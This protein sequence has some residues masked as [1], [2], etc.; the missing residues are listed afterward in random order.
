MGKSL[1]ARQVT[2]L[3]VLVYLL[4]GAALLPFYRY[5][6]A[7]DAI[8]YY[9]IARH[10]L[11]GNWSCAVNGYWG[12]MLSWLM[13]PFL[14]VGLSP[15]LA[16]KLL[17]L[18]AGAVMLLAVSR[19]VTLYA[20]PMLIRAFVLFSCIPFVLYF[21]WYSLSP[22]LLLGVMVALYCVMIFSE[23]YARKTWPGFLCGA[24]G[25]MAYFCKQYGFM[26]F[27][28]HFTLFSLWLFIS[29]EE[30]SRRRQVAV[31]YAL[32]MCV[33]MVL[34]ACWVAALNAKYGHPTLGTAG[35]YNQSILGPDSVG[36]THH[37]YGFLPLP[38]EDAVSA[39]EDPSF[40]PYEPWRP[41][42]SARAMVY[43][44]KR[45]LYNIGALAE[46]YLILSVFSI[47][48]MLG[49]A[50]L[51]MGPWR[52]FRTRREWYPLGVLA[53]FSGG[54]T[55]VLIDL[56]FFAIAAVLT[57]LVTGLVLHALLRN[58]FFRGPLRRATLCVILLLS[59]VVYPGIKL[60]GHLHTGKIYHQ[61]ARPLAALLGH[62][63][64]LASNEDWF[65]SLYYAALTGNKYLGKAHADWTP[66]A[67]R[68][69]LAAH[70]ID[71]YFV[72]GVDDPNLPF[73]AATHRELRQDAVPGL[74]VFDISGVK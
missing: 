25:A 65:T 8:S 59:F 53:V 49:L 70:A 28:A 18:L 72:W 32:G 55:L 48:A 20:L 26:F 62:D 47:A 42:E 46:V 67:L 39:W 66:D 56:R 69:Q 1:T 16:G 29:H 57:A 6:I 68:E 51:C 14:A 61:R 12:P 64:R 50:L 44:L 13:V 34:S 40:F 31:N 30:K 63:K 19:L 58:D 33:F 71:Y 60:L 74:R 23:D 10:Y 36:H 54:Y 24:L 2:G 11:A 3:A 9:A 73:L 17:T 41:T 45:T 15:V 52:T 38:Y 4:S 5:Q 21:A 22:D 7:P 37:T 27:A 35:G 43:T